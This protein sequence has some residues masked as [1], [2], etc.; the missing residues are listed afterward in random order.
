MYPVHSTE[1]YHNAQTATHKLTNNQPTGSLQLIAE[2][3]SVSVSHLT[4]KESL[5]IASNT[6]G[7]HNPGAKT[8]PLVAWQ[9]LYS[10]NEL[11]DAPRH[12]LVIDDTVDD[13]AFALVMPDS[14][15]EPL[16]LPFEILIFDPKSVPKDRDY[17]LIKM[18]DSNK[19]VFRQ[20]IYDANCIYFKPLYSDSSRTKLAILQ[21][22]DK[23]IACLVESRNNYLQTNM[24]IYL[25]GS[26]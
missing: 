5:G 16:F 13:N 17:V 21:P 8:I 11:V 12:T 4:G 2:Y 1:K 10:H 18:H 14:S 6:K 26:L 22:Q 25:E 20:I 23:I 3:F 7:I 15:M 19:F 24:N 9:D